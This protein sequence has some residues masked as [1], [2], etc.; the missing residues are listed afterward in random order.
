MKR[1]FNTFF[2]LLILY[3]ICGSKLSFGQWTKD[4]LKQNEVSTFNNHYAL[5]SIASDGKGGAFISYSIDNVLKLKHLNAAGFNDDK[6]TFIVSGLENIVRSTKLVS[7]LRG[8]VFAIWAVYINNTGNYELRMRH[9]YA[10]GTYSYIYNLY[11]YGDRYDTLSFSLYSNKKYKVVSD[12]QG[13]FWIIMNFKYQKNYTTSYYLSVNHVNPFNEKLYSSQSKSF[14]IE[15][16]K[17]AIDFDAAANSNGALYIASEIN[18]PDSTN[19]NLTLKFDYIDVGYGY[20]HSDIIDNTGT[21]ILTINPSIIATPSRDA[22]VSWI[23]LRSGNDDIYAEKLNYEG[24]KQWATYG[25]PVCTAAN[26]QSSISMI[27]DMRGGAYLSW[28]DRRN[29]NDHVD[30]YMQHINSEGNLTFPSQGVGIQVDSNYQHN[31]SLVNSN[32]GNIIITFFNELIHTRSTLGNIDAVELDSAG[33]L[34]WNKV[35]SAITN[36]FLN[37]PVSDCNGGVII[38]YQI[39]DLICARAI[40]RYGSMSYE[41]KIKSVNDVPD[42]QGGKLAINWRAAPLDTTGFNNIID[43]YTIWRAINIV[44]NSNSSVKNSPKHK[45]ISSNGN[46]RKVSGSYWEKVGEV[47]AHKLAG[48]MKTDLTPIDSNVNHKTPYIK[49]FVSAVTN[50]PDVY[51]DSNIDSAYSVDNTPPAIPI[52]LYLSSDSYITHLGWSEESTPD[53]YRYV[54]YQGTSADFDTANAERYYTKDTVYNFNYSSANKY[55]YKVL[56]VDIH[57]N[58]SELSNE[59]GNPVVPVELESFAAKSNQDKVILNW[60]TA[61]EKNS[62]EFEIERADANSKKYVYHKIG[63]VKGAGNSSTPKSYKFI[64]ENPINSNK[65]SYRLKLIDLDGQISY[66]NKVE[67]DV[68]PSAYHVYQNYPNPFNPVTTIKYSLPETANVSLIIYNSLGKKV[69]T[70][71]NEQHE[72]GY[73]SV[74]FNA[75]DLASGIYFYQIKAGE[76]YSAIKKMILL[77]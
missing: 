63:F 6:K 52:H 18:D 51:W 38:N 65:F 7:D 5:S 58:Q 70:L 22:I 1:S 10:D 4:T 26:D 39:G 55:F 12:N 43:K 76:K 33:N 74:N 45:A 60:K 41:P 47:N 2:I 53:L 59:A 68:T 9:Y 57:G 8:G 46:I 25:N 77:K 67:V 62:N 3:F 71:L 54:I 24:I 69:K 17:S 64:D 44:S 13:G 42:D 49:Y 29:G 19:V 73:H 48:Y 34:L 75:V 20:Y 14:H 37:L 11:T 27:S 31:A 23:D 16:S 32:N 15:K 40:N 61:T 50:D 28:K 21:G 72:A 66:S 56:A 35:A 36:S 30:L